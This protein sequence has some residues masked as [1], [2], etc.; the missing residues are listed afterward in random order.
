MT[1]AEEVVR[2]ARDRR[3]DAWVF[4]GLTGVA[5][6]ISVFF[7][8]QFH[9]EAIAKANYERFIEGAQLQVAD[10]FAEAGKFRASLYCAA[11]V[12]YPP[13][14]EGYRVRP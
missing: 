11:V 14:C 7:V 5:V 9:G 12:P 2:H 3:E 4:G 8:G 6:L 10:A 13:Y 1:P